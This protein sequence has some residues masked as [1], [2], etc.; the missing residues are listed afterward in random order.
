MNKI[1]ATL[2]ILGAIAVMLYQVVD[3][4]QVAKE[5]KPGMEVFDKAFEMIPTELPLERINNTFTVAEVELIIDPDSPEI[6]NSDYSWLRNTTSVCGPVRKNNMRLAMNNDSVIRKDEYSVI[7]TACT[8]YIESSKIAAKQDL[9][10]F[11][12]E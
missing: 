10:E 8:V 3:M 2:A 5:Y 4:D 6:D 7:M 12:N 11:L 1:L 9:R